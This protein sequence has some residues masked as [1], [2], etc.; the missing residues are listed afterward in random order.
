M[1]ALSLFQ[2]V[3]CTKQDVIGKAL[4]EPSDVASLTSDLTNQLLALIS[5]TT[6]ALKGVSSDKYASQLKGAVREL[7]EACGNL[8]SSAGLLQQRPGDDVAKREVAETAR[9]VARQVTSVVAQLQA[10]SRGTQACIDAR[11][12]VEDTVTDLETSLMFATAGSLLEEAPTS[13]AREQPTIKQAAKELVERTKDLVTASS[14]SQ[15]DLAGAA[16]SLKANFTS[17]VAALKQG[18]ASLGPDQLDAQVLLLNAAKDV[19]STLAELLSATKTVSGSPNDVRVLHAR[20]CL[21]VYVY[22]CVSVCFCLSVS[23]CPCSPFCLG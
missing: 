14:E 5:D 2:P 13:F 3:L 11:V 16:D 21:C 17:L 6:G 23:V 4:S 18:A 7:G 15:E 20:V 19:G 9:A 1:S 12:A 8:V 10:G 22:L